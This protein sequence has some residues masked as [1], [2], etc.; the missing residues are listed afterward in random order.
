MENLTAISRNMLHLLE[1]KI[2]MNSLYKIFKTEKP[3]IGAIHLSPL[4]GYGGFDGANKVLRRARS[5]TEA[6]ERG[7]ISGIII[8]NNYDLPHKIT[9]GPETVAIMT[10]I[11]REIAK[12][13]SLPIGVSVLWNDYKAALAIAKVI[14][15]KFIRV[16]V[17][18]DTVRTDFGDITGNAKEV[19]AY[20]K[21]IGAEDIAIFAD[22]Q[23][24]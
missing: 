13:T 15:G 3:I 23:V 17:F 11:I 6:F 19:L 12:K 9:V 18:V 16:P 7:G 5:D 21:K 20:R 24:K 8:E 4:L 1:G 22:I 2:K 10:Y 14:S